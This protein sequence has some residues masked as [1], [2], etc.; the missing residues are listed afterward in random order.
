M[1]GH[2][3]E[4]LVVDDNEMNRDLLLR[5]LTKMGHNVSMA[6][7]GY[8]A[9]AM[10]E[11]KRFDL[12]LLDVMMPDMN[13]YEVL[14]R[15]K[16]HDVWRHIP[17][18][19]ISALT[20]ME[21]IVKCISMGAEDYLPK[22]FK[23]VLLTARVNASL[24]KRRLRDQ[25]ELHL[26]QLSEEKQRTEDLLHVIF[27]QAVLEE[28][29]RTNT[30]KP[31]RYDSVAV[32]FTDIVNFTEYCD[33][34]APETVVSHLQEHVNALE[35]I[36]QRC[37]VQKIKTIGDAFMGTAGLLKEMENPVEA[38]V[39]CA[40]EMVDVGKGFVSGWQIRVGID[41]GPVMGGIVGHRQ[42]LF[43]LWGDAV[44]TAS[45]IQEAGEP[46]CVSVSEK[47]WECLEGRYEA[48]KSTLSIKG[49]GAVPIYRLQN[50]VLSR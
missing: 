19:M 22:P 50:P 43:D 8:Q 23:T 31:R 46:N 29:K 10:M 37:G 15:L 35:N 41:Y 34:N 7:D 14:E 42:Y 2:Q 13:G 26:R 27:P 20:E 21:S 24:E 48:E 17:V 18:V 28:L 6:A 11:E 5:R 36:A 4:V 39:Q 47:A 32:I 25:E 45:R 1:D 49:K 3:G 12:V 44:N 40:L 30:V 9:L 16:A 38:C 33:Q